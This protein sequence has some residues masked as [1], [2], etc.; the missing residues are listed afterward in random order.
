MRGRDGHASLI[1]IVDGGCHRAGVKGW[2]ILT[3]PESRK[4]C[5]GGQSRM[6]R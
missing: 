3:Q 4:K 2:K 6:K 5:R 1:F